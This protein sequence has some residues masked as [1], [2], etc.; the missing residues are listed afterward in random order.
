MRKLV[1]ILSLIL[2]I[3]IFGVTIILAGDD[4]DNG[5]SG[6][7]GDSRNSD[8]NS[9]STTGDSSPKS[10]NQKSSDTKSDFVKTKT[11]TKSKDL[12]S[13]DKDKDKGPNENK[14]REKRESKKDKV[15]SKEE[16]IVVDEH[17]REI[18]I[19]TEIKD[20]KIEEKR[21]FID[22]NGNKVTIIN[23]TKTEDGKN[24]SVFKKKIETL[25]GTE[26]TIKTKT[27]LKEGKQ[28]TTN[29]VEV[30]GVEISTKLSVKEKI[31]GTIAKFKAKLSTGDEQEIISPDNAILKA[32]EELGT[33][34][35]LTFELKENIE[36]DKREAVFSAKAINPGKL[37]G[38]INT[39]LPIETLIDAN[40]T[41]IKTK[42][43]WWAVFVKELN[44]AEVCHVSD[45]SLNK[46]VTL[47]IG[48]PAVKS[49][50]A[51]GDILGKCEVVCGDNLTIEGSEVCDSDNKECVINGYKG[52]EKCNAECTG[53]D[54]CTALE[55]C[56]DGII[57]GIEA[58]DD[59][60]N[61][62]GDG[63]SIAC[64]IEPVINQTITN[65]T[66]VIEDTI[67]I[68]QA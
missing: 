30:N 64:Q 33:T 54:Q 4:N 60:N 51:H 43:P 10:D 18:R 39:N 44:K 26:I 59:S 53:Y 57:N 1:I 27:E 52:I 66:L 65:N 67:I 50:L 32:L 45:E 46:R 34:N 25:D 13:N 22:E 55:S 5:N 19:K 9:G 23:E 6:S 40:G 41:L 48:I 58:C 16:I 63:C 68:G 49:H 8:S 38:I 29:S 47:S 62:N 61:I 14:D 15:E 56:G 2:I 35:N 20:G 42:K 37:F 31:D 36:G 11:E 28:K 12:E 21:T 7:G 24:E 17:G 3:E